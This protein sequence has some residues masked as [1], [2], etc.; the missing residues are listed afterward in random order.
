MRPGLRTAGAGPSREPW[1]RTR[2]REPWDV[3]SCAVSAREA[4]VSAG[5]WRRPEAPPLWR[6]GGRRRRPLRRPAEEPD[7]ECAGDGC[8]TR[9]SPLTAMVRK[10]EHCSQVRAEDRCRSGVRQWNWPVRPP[11]SC[12]WPLVTARPALP[13]HP[14]ERR[15][16]PW[17]HL[18]TRA[19]P[20]AQP[21]TQRCEQDKDLACNH[22]IETFQKGGAYNSASSPSAL[23]TC[24]P[25]SPHIS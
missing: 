22:V 12:P 23:P 15:R 11:S 17:A 16:S 9:A 13:P 5:V 18:D 19:N 6:A 8:A 1:G 10:I 20:T 14:P 4:A 3:A 2:S 25:P 24:L 7:Q 21:L